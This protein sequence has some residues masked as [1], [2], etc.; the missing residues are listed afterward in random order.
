MKDIGINDVDIALMYA[1]LPFCVFIAPPV[2]GFFA[3]KLGNY[4]RVLLMSIV[5]CAF[6]HSLL[7]AVP[8]NL[9]HVDYPETNMTM[10]ETDVSLQWKTCGADQACTKI[11][12]HSDK[13]IITALLLL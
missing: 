5:G 4:I 12:F 10:K 3:D 8:T 7:L 6:F 2:V 1:I 13:I 11:R 9:R